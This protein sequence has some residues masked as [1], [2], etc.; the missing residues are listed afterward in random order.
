[1]KQKEGKISIL[2]LILTIILLSN[3]YFFYILL[4]APQSINS[5][6]IV[7]YKSTNQKIIE[8]SVPI[9]FAFSLCLLAGLVI[10]NII[11]YKKDIKNER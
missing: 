2:L 4:Q 7:L 1:M 5:E 6:E 10:K 9:F 3:L 11:K 8:N